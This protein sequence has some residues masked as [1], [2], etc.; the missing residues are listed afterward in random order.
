[1]QTNRTVFSPRSEMSEPARQREIEEIVEGLIAK[2]GYQSVINE[3]LIALHNLAE[4]S[5]ADLQNQSNER[6]SKMWA[7]AVRT[8]VKRHSEE[9]TFEQRVDGS[10]AFRARGMGIRLD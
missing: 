9:C 6:E 5:L 4:I 7:R 1:M 2:R 3:L 10:D 8:A